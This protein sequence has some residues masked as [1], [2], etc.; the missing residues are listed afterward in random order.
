[1][2]FVIA[3]GLLWPLGGRRRPTGMPPWP[4]TLALLLFVGLMVL[5]GV[6]SYAGLRT[7][8]NE[9]RMLTGLATGY[10]IAAW[11]TPLLNAQLWVRSSGD[12]LL[13]SPLRSLAFLAS[14]SLA[15]AVVWYAAPLIGIAYVWLVAAAIIVTFTTVNLVIVT[16]F[17]PFERAYTR[18]RDAW[19][20]ISLAVALSL[21]ELALASGIK[22]WLMRFAG[23]V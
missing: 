5:D 17:P 14:V 4:T 19:L 18:L 13:G 10:A 7:T 12:R 8:T 6:T 22:V 16:L 23:L 11:T 1:M 2:G 15:Y 3:L 21:L 20:P 9:L